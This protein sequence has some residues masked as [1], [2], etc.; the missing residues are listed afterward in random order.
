MCTHTHTVYKSVGSNKVTICFQPR[1]LVEEECE[2]SEC[3]GRRER[4][5]KTH[6]KIVIDSMCV[7][8]QRIQ[9][10]VSQSSLSV[11]CEGSGFLFQLCTLQDKAS[12]SPTISLFYNEPLFQS[13]RGESFFFFKQTVRFCLENLC[14]PAFPS[15]IHVFGFSSQHPNFSTWVTVAEWIAWVEQLLTPS[16]SSNTQYCQRE[17]AV[18]IMCWNYFRNRY[19]LSL[20]QTPSQKPERAQGRA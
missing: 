5:V 20:S 4:S 12:W 9:D 11:K 7:C 15:E 19:A 2:V 8:A 17:W 6:T 10:E 3:I 1:P 16:Y 13:F 18:S 14:H